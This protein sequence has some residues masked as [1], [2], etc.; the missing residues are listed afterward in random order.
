MLRIDADTRVE[1]DTFH[2]ARELASNVNAL[3]QEQPLGFHTLIYINYGFHVKTG[4]LTTSSSALISIFLNRM[5]GRPCSTAS[6]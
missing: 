1:A 6:H 2:C 4:G 5:A 3:Q